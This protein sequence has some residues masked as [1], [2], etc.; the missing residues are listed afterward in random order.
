[1]TNEEHRKSNTFFER[2]EILTYKPTSINIHY[3]N[4]L[5]KM[6]SIVSCKV[7]RSTDI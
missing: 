3:L 6:S 5:M 4:F 7:D 2:A 1:M